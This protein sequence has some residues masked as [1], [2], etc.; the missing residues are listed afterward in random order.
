[1]RD[2]K[3]L[4]LRA[5]IVNLI[6]LPH[7]FPISVVPKNGIDAR[8]ATTRTISAFDVSLT[9]MF[10]TPT[11]ILGPVGHLPKSNLILMPKGNRSLRRE[12]WTCQLLRL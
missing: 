7:R 9:R 1:M 12:G 5:I 11:A 2:R 8:A 4:L 10:Y 6:I 3:T